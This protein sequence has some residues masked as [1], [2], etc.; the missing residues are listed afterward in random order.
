MYVQVL[1]KAKEGIRCLEQWF[2]TWEPND[3]FMG[4]ITGILHFRD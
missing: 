2:S 1:I 3:A 4:V